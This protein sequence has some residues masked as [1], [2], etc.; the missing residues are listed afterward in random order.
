MYKIKDRNLDFNMPDIKKVFFQEDKNGNYIFKFYLFD[1]EWSLY[2]MR[3]SY[4]KAILYVYDIED[5]NQDL[6]R[7]IPI[8]FRTSYSASFEFT[9]NGLPI[10]NLFDFDDI[11]D[12]DELNKMLFK[13]IAQLLFLTFNNMSRE[14]FLEELTSL[15]T[16]L[17]K[18]QTA[19]ELYNENIDKY[20][21]KLHKMLYD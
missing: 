3:N 1:Y 19:V 21:E 15:R 20:A 17:Q 7:K 18:R 13:D 6:E 16:E 8:K 9:N 4:P 11:K 2:V 5:I 12:D 14:D 10:Q